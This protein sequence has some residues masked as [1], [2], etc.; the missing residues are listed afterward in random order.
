MT[1]DPCL[2]L[3]SLMQRESV[4]LLIGNI[5]AA[6]GLLPKHHDQRDRDLKEPL[7]QSM[8]QDFPSTSQDFIRALKAPADP[9]SGHAFSKIQMASQ[10]WFQSTFY[11]PNKDQAITDWILN[12]FLKEKDKPR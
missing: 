11:F 4:V 6:M 5:S 2:C 10:A 12:R 8:Q 7:P 1:G 9:P 3:R